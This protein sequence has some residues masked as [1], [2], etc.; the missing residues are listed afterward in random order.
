[1]SIGKCEF[2]GK[3]KKVV[4]TTFVGMYCKD[5]HEI[6]IEE[7]RMA[8]RAINALRSSPNSKEGKH[9]L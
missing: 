3:I 7:S 2:C 6:N 8:I 9:D 5:C 1:M 4:S